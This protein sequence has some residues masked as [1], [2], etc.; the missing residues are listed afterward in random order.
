MTRYAALLRGINVGGNAK[1]EM[2]RLKQVFESLGCEKVATYINSGNVI[3]S[4][5]RNHN[6]LVPIIEKALNKEFGLGLK[7]VLRSLEQIEAICR[8]VP[9]TWT[10]D[11]DQKTDVMFLWEQIDN[12]EILKKV[13]INPKLENVKYIAGAL[14]WNIARKNVTKGGGIKLIKTD[15]YPLMTVRNINTVR[16]LRQLMSG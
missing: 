12:K 6:Q 15:L 10:N 4:D 5:K 1:V 11:G 2:P 16:K 3:F 9:E 7:V 14:V 8:A 13:V